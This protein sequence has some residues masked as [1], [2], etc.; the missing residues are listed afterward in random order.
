V[1]VL[2]EGSSTE[3]G[4][5]RALRSELRLPRASIE[6]V[7]LGGGNPPGVAMAA[8]AHAAKAGRN[9]PEERFD[10]LWAVCD[11]DDPRRSGAAAALARMVDSG[12]DVALSHPTF[13]VWLLLHH[14]DVRGALHSAEAKRRVAAQ[15]E[16]AVAHWPLAAERASRIRMEAVPAVQTP[17]PVKLVLA[18]NPSTNVDELVQLLADEAAKRRV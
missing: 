9:R 16:T 15:G 11:T 2:C 6:L 12:L 7:G 1:L 8:V 14:G 13:E 5:F 4:Y 18:T 3:V 10:E 17:H